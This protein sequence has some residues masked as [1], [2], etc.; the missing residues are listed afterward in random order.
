MSHLYRGPR[1]SWVEIKCVCSF[2]LAKVAETSEPLC[3]RYKFNFV[4]N[5]NW[6][7]N[8]KPNKIKKILGN[9][10][11][12]N[13][14]VIFNIDKVF[15]FK[16]HHNLW[17]RFLYLLWSDSNSELGKILVQSWNLFS[18][19]GLTLIKIRLLSA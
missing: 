3:R 16:S 15:V 14:A 7:K 19:F 6:D 8:T 12:Q 1:G 18:I 9:I 11:L 5:V 2:S 13:Q 4:F 10:I 17:I